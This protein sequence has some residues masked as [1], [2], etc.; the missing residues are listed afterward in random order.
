[1]KKVVFIFLISLIKTYLVTYKWYLIILNFQV[2]DRKQTLKK[3]N[4]CL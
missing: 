3:I 2:F 1:M 4:L